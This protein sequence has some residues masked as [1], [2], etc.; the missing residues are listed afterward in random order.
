MTLQYAYLLTRKVDVIINT[1][2]RNHLTA[3]LTFELQNV[4]LF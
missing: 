4:Y 1:D 2:K 3:I